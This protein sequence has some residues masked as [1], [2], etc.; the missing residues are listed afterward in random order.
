MAGEADHYQVEFTLSKALLT[1]A[2][3]ICRYVRIGKRG[4]ILAFS[5]VS[6]GFI[7]F[8]AADLLTTDRLSLEDLMAGTM[9]AALIACIFGTAMLQSLVVRSRPALSAVG[10]VRFDF[11]PQGVAVSSAAGEVLWPWDLVRGVEEQADLFLLLL[12]DS[13]AVIPKHAVGEKDIQGFRDMLHAAVA[14]R[15]RTYAF[16]VQPGRGGEHIG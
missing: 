3:W 13:F 2:A 7:V 16:P 9:M 12:A 8:G 6:L 15:H 11:G 1:R 5:G 10:P 14:L 4:G